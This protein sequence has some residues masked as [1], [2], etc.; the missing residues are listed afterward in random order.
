MF[1][2]VA[3]IAYQ[4]GCL[5]YYSGNSRED[6]QNF[7]HLAEQFHKKYAKQIE[8]NWEETGMDY[9][10][11]ID[12]FIESN[13]KSQRKLH[14]SYPK[15]FESEWDNLE[16]ERCREEA[17]SV[18]VIHDEND[19]EPTDFWSVYAHQ[20]SGGV[21]CVADVPTERDAIQLTDTIQKAVKSFK[22]N[23]FMALYNN[24]RLKKTIIDWCNEKIKNEPKTYY[25]WKYE[26]V[27]NFVD[28]LIW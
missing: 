19:V 9:M 12:K 3:D 15:A 10:D 23:G 20:V 22:N 27:K 1:E 24:D 21:M 6:M 17:G 5:G 13:I 2:T 18:S 25:K 7:I 11:E 28:K 26:E 14:L 16:I 8:A 4:A